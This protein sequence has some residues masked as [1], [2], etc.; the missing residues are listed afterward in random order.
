MS[1]NICCNDSKLNKLQGEKFR[2]DILFKDYI[3][4][5]ISVYSISRIDGP[6]RFN[7]FEYFYVESALEYAYLEIKKDKENNFISQVKSFDSIFKG[8]YFTFDETATLPL[9]KKI[10]INE[11]LLSIIIEIGSIYS[12]KDRDDKIIEV[13][14]KLIKD[15]SKN[16]V[17]EILYTLQY[18]YTNSCPENIFLT[19]K[20]LLQKNGFMPDKYTILSLIQLVFRFMT[21]D[22]ILPLRSYFKSNIIDYPVFFVYQNIPI[23]IGDMNKVFFNFSEFSAIYFNANLKNE[24]YKLPLVFQEN[25]SDNASSWIFKT[26]QKRLEVYYELKHPAPDSFNKK[27]IL[28]DIKKNIE[29]VILHH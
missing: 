7:D 19:H 13:A 27:D 9:V 26:Y 12:Y 15:F 22:E 28:A 21:P 29:W 11:K 24:V 25:F 8:D 4:E 17:L 23:C 3:K 10:K 1:A 20:N 18:M 16:E 5:K 14:N 6:Y 2:Y